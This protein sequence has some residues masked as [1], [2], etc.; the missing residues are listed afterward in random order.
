MRM[1]GQWQIRRRLVEEDLLLWAWRRRERSHQPHFTVGELGEGQ[2]WA[3]REA[4]VVAQRLVRT[5]LL[6]VSE[7]AYRLTE[8]G[9]RYTEDLIRR[10]RLYE[11]YLYGLGYPTDHVHAPADR[12]EHHLSP[13]TVAALAKATSDTPLD[14]HD[15][16][17]PPEPPT[18]KNHE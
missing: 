15:K 10:H 7:G 5:R 11:S 14:P 3:V 12:V 2:N 4:L 17:I 1:I 8:R 9:L 6:A 16:P 13:A 18:R